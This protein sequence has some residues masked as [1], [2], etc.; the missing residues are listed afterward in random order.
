MGVFQ[1]QYDVEWTISVVLAL[2][3]AFAFVDALTRPAQGFAA[4]DKLTKVAWLWLTGAGLASLL[5]FGALSLFG[6][7]ATV[8]VFVY[9]LDVRPAVASATRR[10]P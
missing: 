6:L 1:L 5:L 7:L 3:G 2:V 4:A 8:A 10:R 9:L